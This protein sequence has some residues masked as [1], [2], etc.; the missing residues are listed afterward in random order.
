MAYNNI[1]TRSDVAGIIPVEYSNELL[2]RTQETSHLLR[3]ARPLRNMTAYEKTLPVLSALAQAY[4]PNG[5]TGLVQT[6]EVNW[7]NKTITAEDIV[8]FVPI[9][10]NSLN[11]AS[12]P[13]WDEVMPEVA[14]AVGAAIDNAQLYGTNKP[15]TWPTAIVTAATS[16]SHTVALGTGADL[17]DDLLSEGGVFGLV[18]ADGYM[19]NGAIGHLSMKAKLRGVRGSDGVPIFNSVPQAPGNYTLDGAPIYFPTNGSGSATNLLIAGDWNQLVY[20]MRQDME[21]EVFTEGV[22]QDAGGN[23]IYNLM[24]QRM[25]ALMV[26]I[27]LGFQLPNPINRVNETEATRYPFAIL[28]SS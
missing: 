21:F 18:E 20:S 24:Q 26:T 23:I 16:A 12:I 11:D 3:L 6:T 22:I 9:S 27:R 17:Y 7:T 8:G 2:T 13:I 28:T 1:I 25:A 19:V 14:T 4:F 15:T 10:K 5:E